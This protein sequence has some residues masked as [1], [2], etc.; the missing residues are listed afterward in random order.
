MPTGKSPPAPAAA[1]RSS[2]AS[3]GRKFDTYV[4]AIGREL[5]WHGALSVDII[6]PDDGTRA[7]ADRLQSAAGRA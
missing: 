1:R 3:A 6:M 5:G 2:K 7:A 4:A